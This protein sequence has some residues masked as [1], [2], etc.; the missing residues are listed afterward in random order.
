RTVFL[1]QYL[2][3]R[4]LAYLLRV[5]GA[6]IFFVL[7]QKFSYVIGK[8]LRSCEYSVKS[9]SLPPGA[10]LALMCSYHQMDKF[11]IQNGGYRHF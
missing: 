2:I 1:A 7:R 3:R 4:L 10:F 11:W 8:S 9:L 5:R 6:A